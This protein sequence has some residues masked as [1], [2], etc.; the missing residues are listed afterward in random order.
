MKVNNM[1]EGLKNYKWELTYSTS[2]LKDNGEPTD[3][4]HDFYIPALKR[5]TE[6]DRVAGYF[7]SSSLAAASQGY[8]SF[9]NHGGKMR[10]IV[11]ADL[12]LQDVA[13]ILAGN[14]QRLSD[15]LME[16]LENEDT[17]PEAVRNGVALLGEMVSSGRLK[18][19]VAFRV[20]ASTNEPL[21]VDSTEDGYVHEKWFVMKDSEGNRIYGSGSLNE[22]RTALVLNAENIDI[23]CDW[24]SSK[25]AL[26]VCGAEERF[27]A[28][29][30]NENPYMV[31]KEIPD[32][33]RDRLIHLKTITNKPTEIDGTVIQTEIEPSVE[34]MLK[35]AVLRD[36]P[37]MPNGLYV[38]MYSA[39]VEPWPHQEIVSRKLIESHPYSYL[40]CD[41]V[42]LG[43]TIE[44]ALAMRS[45]I[46]SG[47]AKKV[48][49]VAPASLT[50][51][52]QREL[53]Q[54]AMLPFA[55]T[56]VRPGGTGKID[57]EY[58]YP[59]PAE[60]IDTDLY[61]PDF[62]IISSGLVSRK[63]RVSAIDRSEECDVILVDEAHY[64]RRQNPRG[65]S[66]ETAKYGNLYK[67]ID[68]HLKKKAKGLWLATA[69]PMQIDA[70][71]VF[72][73]FRLTDRTGQYEA[74]PTLSM[75]Y[76][77]LMGKLI[78]EMSL[79]R[80]QWAIL[81][82]SYAQIE[83]LDPFLW[84]NIQ[85]TAVTS[86]NRKVLYN[87]PLKDPMRADVKYLKQPMFSASPLSRVMMR[88]TR[89]LLEIYRQNGELSSNLATRHIRPICAIEF[90]PEE[91]TFYNS[92]EDYCSG[93]NE[94]MRKYNHQL[95]QIMGFYL[96][97]LQLR[98]ASSFY[99]IQ[100]TLTRR[101]KRVNQTLILG[102]RTFETEEE[103]QDAIDQLRDSDEYD[104]ADISEITFDALLKDRNQKDLEWERDELKKM[105]DHLGL[106]SQTPS[107]IQRL[108]EELSARTVRGRVRQTVLFTRF[109]DTLK[110][111]RD[112]LRI[113]S[114]G[115]R[116]G[117]YSGGH[118]EWYDPEAGRDVSTTHEEIKR[119]FL[120]GEID[121]LLCTD[122]AA[123]GLNLQTADLLINFD[124]GWN[125][126]KIEQRIG[127]ID[128]IGQKYSDIE[129]MNMCYLGSTEEKVY[130][131]LCERLQLAGLVVGA[132]QISMLPVDQEMFR[133]LH[134]GEITLEQ[135]EK[136]AKD[137]LK[138]QKE[139]TAQME[140]SPQDMYDMYHRISGDMHSKE[141]PADLQSIWDAFTTSSYFENL[142]AKILPNGRW[143]LPASDYASEF[144]GT[145]SREMAD[146]P[147]EFM[148]WG[149]DTI[150][151]IMNNM[152][153]RLEDC[154]CVKR[155]S[156]TEGIVE[157]GGYVVATTNGKMLITSY[158]SLS[159]LYVDHT[160]TIE[161][162][163]IKSAKAKLKLIAKAEAEKTVVAMKAI[164]KNA[165]V[166]DLHETLVRSC[167]VAVLEK[168]KNSGINKYSDIAKALTEI[169]NPLF[170]AELP[171]NKFTGKANL[172]VFP[173]FEASGKI[174][175]NICGELYNSC[176][177]LIQRSASELHKKKTEIAVEDVLHRVSPK[178]PTI[179]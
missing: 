20:K 138:K 179:G 78:G 16:E 128:R 74:D 140:M 105:I 42:G 175:V 113:R 72:D 118:A 160:S 85:K 103:F 115:M 46:L 125:P 67:S 141:Y 99:A 36:A 73:L 110:N 68:E 166:A 37:K 143:H 164:K 24:D 62:N 55:K 21:S 173:I 167:A 66:L 31:V 122:A 17:W 3:I 133:K 94:Q 70:I 81:G 120:T 61:S 29:W 100:Q 111:I 23:H 174:S 35:F 39:P 79:T 13:A 33:V 170:T 165:E 8:T 112:Y 121:L 15:K 176:S 129:V 106:M 93:L 108:L 14:N 177:E 139:A 96:N 91:E 2:G 47:R 69:T 59:R 132:Q 97:F 153:N 82:Q 18:I 22:S 107:K 12:Q 178:K 117:V 53:A 4:L 152:A 89:R 43:K 63:E 48:M 26:R 159:G 135:L 40:M 142:G 30:S 137:R 90:T 123:E 162:T 168:Y 5:I 77:Q 116:V 75:T 114:S 161:E 147:E 34:E 51:Q 163:D 54:K 86:K 83:A 44:A 11:G 155:V 32:A 150:D 145:I 57:H 154:P 56:R 131:R 124:L 88:H 104:E 119:L 64:A 76:F 144:T 60:D 171:Y 6:Y 136:E 71:E 127:R 84:N 157:V 172:L 45:L 101:L 149:N 65:G 146:T 41:E 49:I 169:K 50:D 7:R 27:N 109:Y 102:G 158:S 87:L 25:D 156:V 19:K 1:E 126:M 151:F 28:L 95:R 148:T 38:G 52:W 80:Q 134:S 10:M 92:L 130:G 9:L 58:I 98:F